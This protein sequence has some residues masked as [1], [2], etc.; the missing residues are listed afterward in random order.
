MSHEGVHQSDGQTYRSI[1]S[2]SHVG[3]SLSRRLESPSMTSNEPRNVDPS[4]I[5]YRLWSRRAFLRSAI[6]AGSG[7]VAGCAGQE[8]AVPADEDGTGDGTVG[9]RRRQRD[10]G[11]ERHR[12]GHPRRRP[13]PAPPRRIRVLPV[14][15]PRR[16]RRR[17]D[18]WVTPIQS[19]GA[20]AF[21]RRYRT[22]PTDGLDRDSRDACR[23][24]Y[25]AL[26]DT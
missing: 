15:G 25:R 3:K 16:R 4:R 10:G 5:G 1:E 22:R 9:Q 2:I 13:A 11:W 23:I 20:G 12:S 6:G 17:Q 21:C 19:L 18:P 7:D 14:P 24:V 8:S 26:E